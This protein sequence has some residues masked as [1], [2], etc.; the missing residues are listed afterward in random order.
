MKYS[1]KDNE[2]FY[3]K[4]S[5][6][7]ISL[8][9]NKSNQTSF[10]IN[11]TAKYIYNICKYH[12]STEDI[13]KH[14]KEK[15]RNVDEKI[16]ERDVKDFFSI[17]SIYG[18]IE[19]EESTIDSLDKGVLIV[20]DNEYFE[21]EKFLKN[22]FEKKEFSFITANNVKYFSTLNMRMHVMSNQ[23]YFF[24]YKL[25]EIKVVI[26]IIPPSPKSTVILINGI[27]YDDGI[28]EVDLKKYID[29]ILNRICE[30]FKTNLKKFRISISEDSLSSLQSFI[31]FI[32][33][34]GFRIE[35]VLHDE[36][37]TGNLVMYTKII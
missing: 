18:V 12:E 8:V 24:A 1:V 21:V 13:V 27:I 32:S 28:E 9:F 33:T 3:V 30:L 7:S 23:E 22:N 35:C 4:D 36:I 16:L 25:E 26:S 19:Y 31:Q 20:G 37:D 5:G 10:Y 17:L 2:L 11:S 14:L 15:Y 29:L 34:L 6:N